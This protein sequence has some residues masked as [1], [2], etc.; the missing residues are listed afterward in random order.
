MK[1]IIILVFSLLGLQTFG[2]T[3]KI[4]TGVASYYASKFEGRRTAT[5]VIFSNMKLTAA[6]NRFK[7]GDTVKVINLKN[8]REIVVI[9]NDRMGNKTRLIDLSQFGAKQLGFYG[10]GLTK[11]SVIK[12]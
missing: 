4:K 10:N 2:Q 6:S 1:K 5:G 8:L 7:L 3:K 12:L 9:I 11:V